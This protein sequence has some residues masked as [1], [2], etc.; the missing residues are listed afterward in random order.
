MSIVIVVDP[1]STG[2]IL[3][4]ALN[5]LYPLHK[6]VGIFNITDNSAS[7]QTLV[8]KGLTL[9]YE[10]IIEF[11]KSKDSFDDLVA[12]LIIQYGK[13][14]IAAVIA[15]AEPG[16]EVADALSERLSLRSNSTLLTE[17]RRNKF[18][19]SEQIR[20]KGLRAVKQFSS[21]SWDDIQ[22]W[23]ESELV[24]DPSSNFKVVVKPQDSAGS[25]CVTLCNNMEEVRA[26]YHS[27]IG[28]SNVLG[29]IT[30]LV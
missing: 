25:D 5:N 19:Q 10:A 16:V 12:R 13:E 1:F 20:S 15:G 3:V 7:L 21:D 6:C 27:I 18:V 4:Q 30:L 26:G 11:N 2:A 28:K 8:P 14:N 24:P 22:S 23:I 29:L 17:A 9:K